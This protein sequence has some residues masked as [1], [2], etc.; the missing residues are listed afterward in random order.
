MDFCRSDVLRVVSSL[1]QSLLDEEVAVLSDIAAGG[2][3]IG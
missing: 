3:L 2:T 1:R